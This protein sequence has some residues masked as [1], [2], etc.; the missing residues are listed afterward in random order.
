MSEENKTAV[1]AVAIAA[2]LYRLF[3]Y[4][5]NAQS[6]VRPGM[7]VSVPFGPKKR[8]GVVMALRNDSGFPLAKLRSVEKVLDDEPLLSIDDLDFLQWV[9]NYYHYPIGEVALMA[10]PLRLRKQQQVVQLAETVW[11]LSSEGEKL[12]A[13]DLKSAPKQLMV[14]QLLEANAGRCGIELLRSRISGVGAVLAR[15]HEKGI[16]ISYESELLPEL[17]SPPEPSRRLTP[18]QDKAVENLSRRVNGFSISLLQGVT[19]SGKTEVYLRFA[20]EVLNKGGS[21]MVLVPEISLTPQLRARFNEALGVDVLLMHSGLAEGA[22]ERA[23]HQMR[24]GLRR[25]VLGTRSLVFNPM[26]NLGLIVVDEEHDQ[27]YKQQE[28]CRYSAR[29]LAIV[30]AK[31]ASCPVLLGSATPSLETLRNAQHG[32]Y[33]YL[34]MHQRAGGASMPKMQLIDVRDQPLRDGLSDPLRKA[35]SDTFSR[36]EQAIIFLNRRGYSPVLTCYSCGW[37]SDCKRCDA[38]QTVHRTS[39]LLWCHH[40]GAQQPIPKK[41]PDCGEED[42]HPLGQGTERLEEHLKESFPQV[43]MIRIDRDSTSRKGSLQA[44]LETVHDSDVAMLVGTQMLAKGHDFPKVTL[45]GIIDIDGGLFSA[46]FRAAERMAQLLLQ[47]AG[48]AG[49]AQK[50]GRVLIQTRHADNELLQTLVHKGYDSFALSALQERKETEFPPYS[51]QALLR[52]ESIKDEYPMDF[53]QGVADW[54]KLSTPRVE[55]WGPVPAPMSRRA[56]KYRGHL[57][58]QAKSREDLHPLLSHMVITL[59]E[60]EGANRVRWHLDVDPVDLY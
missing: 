19:G 60:I 41:C 44:L 40:C 6:N 17:A 7:R 24:L 12:A 20:V 56:G 57:L 25:V 21:V 59:P 29:D 26:K 34:Q 37:L 47:V 42:L 14:Y 5:P 52:A 13:D 4:L 33:N 30:R 39:N 54:V 9:A 27:S 16:L 51:F 23:W 11:A 49:R 48:R 8:I 31:R 50:P 3:D 18:E 46:D 32:R 2:P 58:L 35:L 1:L 36:N 22:R 38:K 55:C 53:L 15:M 28:G 10:L 43:P 45:V